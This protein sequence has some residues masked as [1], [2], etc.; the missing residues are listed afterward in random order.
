MVGSL[1]LAYSDTMYF[2]DAI[3]MGTDGKLVLDR[4][5]FHF[6]CVT[7]NRHEILVRTRRLLA[8]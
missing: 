8:L 5:V 2:S 1:K 6:T 7:G 3:T 4:F